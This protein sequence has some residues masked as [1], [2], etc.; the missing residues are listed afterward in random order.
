MTKFSEDTFTSWTKPP[1]DSEQG[2]LET[3]EKHVKDALSEDPKLNKMSFEVFGQGSYAN[4]TNVRLNSDIDINVMYTGGYY[5]ELPEGATEAD[6]GIDKTPASTY[7]FKEFKNDVE[8]ALIKKF[9]KDQVVRKNK[10]ITV[11]ATPQR[12]QTDVVPTWEFRRFAK[13]KTFESG[14][15]FYPDDSFSPITNYPKQHIKNAIK[16]NSDT[17]KRFKRLTRLHRKIRYKMKEDG[18]PISDNITSFLIE[19]LIWNVPNKI[20]NENDSWTSRLRESIVFLYQQTKEDKTCHEWG[21]VSEL[22]Y[23][24]R[25]GRKWSRTDVNDYMVQLWNYL[26]FK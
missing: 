8:A 14:V 25:G 23:L 6:I 1:S 3:S 9:S 26:E 21:E 20:M 4:D 22:L 16:K 7:S 2:R 5:F 11:K 12:V 18:V 10:C 24:L 19:C 13:N 17:Q 15:R